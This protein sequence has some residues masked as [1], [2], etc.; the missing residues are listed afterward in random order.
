MR[1]PEIEVTG[2]FP[3]PEEERA[4]R[5][6]ILKLWRDDQALAARAQG[7]NAWVAAGRDEATGAS[8]GRGWRR[9][10]GLMQP[11]VLFARRVGRGDQR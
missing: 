10:A 9:S 2:G 11:G 5:E 1:P 3:S 8:S 4:V 6:A 7:G